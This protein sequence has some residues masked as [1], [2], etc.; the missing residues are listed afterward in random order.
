MIFTIEKRNYNIRWKTI[1]K[2]GYKLIIINNNYNNNINNNKTLKSYAL[3]SKSL[4]EFIVSFFPQVS[5]ILYI[6]MWYI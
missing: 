3:L 5:R 1:Y 2:H 6:Y 4:P